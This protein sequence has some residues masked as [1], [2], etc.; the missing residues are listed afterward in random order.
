MATY[1]YFRQPGIPAPHPGENWWWIR[2]DFTIQNMQTSDV[3][4]IAKLK[5]H[6]I[7][8]NTFTRMTIPTTAAATA[9]LGVTSGGQELD[10]AVALDGTDTWV[11]GDAVDD[12][13]PLA[14]TADGY[15]YFECLT[16]AIYD[17]IFDYLV[18]VIMCHTDAE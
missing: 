14:I 1:D 10:A 17:G 3:C 4:R 11:R 5:N 7:I 13:G 18:E 2:L 9:D 8:K 12:D 16:A 6:W 15:I